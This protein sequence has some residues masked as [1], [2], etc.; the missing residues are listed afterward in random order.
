MKRFLYSVVHAVERK[1]FQSCD[2]LIV[3]SHTMARGLREDY[4]VDSGR[5]IVRY[6][7]AT[8]KPTGLGRNLA[9]LLPDGPEH[10]VYSGALGK[11]QNAHGLFEFF[12][13]AARRLP[14]VHFHIFSAGPIFEELRRSASALSIQRISFTIS[15]PSLTSKNST[16]DRLYR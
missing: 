1:T 9:Y 2:S 4:G 8:I 3:L 16:P 10:V 14:A 7:F 11:K 6:P 12:V 15:C 5:V 13:A